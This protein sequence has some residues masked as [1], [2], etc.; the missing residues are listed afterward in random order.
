MGNRSTKPPT[1]NSAPGR[2]PTAS[3]DDDLDE[4]VE[5]ARA[6]GLWASARQGY[7]KH[8]S[9]LP[10]GGLPAGV[11]CRFTW[12]FHVS[13]RTSYEEVVKAIIRPPRAE[14]DVEDLGEWRV[15]HGVG[16]FAPDVCMP[17]VSQGPR[18]SSIAARN[19]IVQTSR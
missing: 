9:Q 17:P 7:V 10:R 6:P 18:N 1:R 19:F 15:Q 8:L 13:F 2:P 12:L 11:A 4:E 3:D 14:Y 16:L 5:E